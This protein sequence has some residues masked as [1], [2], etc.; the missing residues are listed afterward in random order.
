M[1]PKPLYTRVKHDSNLIRELHAVE[2][3]ELLN[4]IIRLKGQLDER[5][6]L[7]VCYL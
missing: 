6:R 1:Y 5:N 2:R 4:E 3:K 7:F